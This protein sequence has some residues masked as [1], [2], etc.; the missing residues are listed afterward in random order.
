[1]EGWISGKLR[2][3]DFDQSLPPLEIECLTEGTK[4]FIGAHKDIIETIASMVG[5]TMVSKD[6]VK[7]LPREKK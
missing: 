6:W 1:M 4:T 7:V 2:E 3:L 5:A